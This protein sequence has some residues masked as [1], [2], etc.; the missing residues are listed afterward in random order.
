M[1]ISVKNAG[2]AVAVILLVLLVYAIIPRAKEEDK[3]EE[4]NV[5]NDNLDKI[6]FKVTTAKVFKG[7]LIKWVNANG[8]VKASKE[9]E[10]QA[11]ISG[12]IKELNAYEGKKAKKDELL[13]FIDDTQYQLAYKNAVA[14]VNSSSVDYYLNLKDSGNNITSD[15]ETSKKEIEQKITDLKK[16]YDSGKMNK[17]TYDKKMDDLDAA[18]LMSGAKRNEVAADKA[19]LTTARNSKLE[20]ELNLSYTKI[21]APFSGVIGDIDLIA[22]KRINAGEKL[23]KIF[24]TSTLKVEVRVLE[25]DVASIN[26]GSFVEVNINSLPNE[27]FTGR[28]ANISPHIDTET[29]TCKVIVE[30]KNM[31]DKIKPGMFA[32][33]NIQAATYKNRLLAPIEALVVRDNRNLV[34]V[35]VDGLAKWEYFDLGEKNDRYIEITSDN[36][37]AGD[38]V[39][40]KGHTN[41]AHDAKIKVIDRK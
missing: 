1:K 28:V 35:A 21:K 13:I 38:E 20:A 26:V 8:I 29:K 11:N 3:V 4:K 17:D 39:V 14:R 18:L 5:N 19:N 34:F 7:D 40:V 25:N 2:I 31:N 16:Q 30:M 36:I 24:E 10:I 32:T 6:E 9:L 37:K 15:V 33:V 12:Y 23:F 22:G 27:K 41:L